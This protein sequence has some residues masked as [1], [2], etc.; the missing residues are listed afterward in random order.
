MNFAQSFAA[1]LDGRTV[2]R[3]SWA[4]FGITLKDGAFHIDPPIR[5][6][7]KQTMDSFEIADTLATDWQC[8][9]NDPEPEIVT[10]IVAC[11]RVLAVPEADLMADPLAIDKKIRE[12]EREGFVF[13]SQE[14]D[15]R[16]CQHVLQFI[17]EA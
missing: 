13:R 15:P 12:Q 10:P 7:A 14:Y 9:D 1:L 17:K 2:R 11:T 5:G 8:C 6:I 16:L 4:D 3:Q